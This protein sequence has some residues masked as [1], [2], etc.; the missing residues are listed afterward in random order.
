MGLTS[1]RLSFQRLTSEGMEYSEVDLSSQVGFSE[2]DL[3]RGGIADGEL[4][5]AFLIFL[6]FDL[7]EGLSPRT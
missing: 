3:L 4:L 5:K 6:H 7:T 2:V 1:H